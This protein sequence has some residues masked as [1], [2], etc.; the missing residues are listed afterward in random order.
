MSDVVNSKEA[1]EHRMALMNGDWPSGCRSCQDFEE[2]GISSTRMGGLRKY[3]HERLLK[4]YD[5][6]T[7]TI[8]HVRSIEIRF[9]NECN[10]TCR[11]C[12]PAFSSRWEA[13]ERMDPSIISKGLHRNHEP[14]TYLTTPGYYKDILE[15]MVPYLDEIMFS[16]GETLYQKEHYEFID[17]I[18]AK[19]ASHIDLFYVTNGT[20]T[21]LKN[22]DA[23][24]IWRKFRKITVVVS[25]DGV[26]EQYEYFRQG[27]NWQ[28]VESNLKLFREEGYHTEAEI[29]C[30][31][32]QVFYLTDSIDYIYDN[33]LCQRITS[34]SVQYPTMVNQRIIPSHVKTELYNQYRKWSDGIN[35]EKKRYNVEFIA[36]KQMDYMMGE[37]SDIYDG[38]DTDMPSWDDFSESV[39]L[40]DRVFK[41]SVDHSF[42]RLAKHLSR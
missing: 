3:D 28:T 19:H 37:N 14:H 8:K 38:P 40:L 35:D 17:A 6:L 27:S 25:T 36:K 24:K 34:A 23:I 13:I 32:Y 33:A 12:G 9:G 31:V 7:G 22:Y 29:T 20:V 10:L 18:P 5:P 26:G 2:Q 15:N 4:D 42:P 30:S 11:H 1:R 21:K 41:T 39:R 16:G